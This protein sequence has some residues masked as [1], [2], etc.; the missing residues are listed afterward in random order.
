[1]WKWQ[2]AGAGGG[3]LAICIPP[4]SSFLSGVGGLGWEGCPCFQRLS[5]T[6][7][8]CRG[9]FHFPLPLSSLSF[10]SFLLGSLRPPTTFV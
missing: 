7:P 8:W 1:M 4:P 5:P 2:Q 9:R 6:P 3:V 10:L